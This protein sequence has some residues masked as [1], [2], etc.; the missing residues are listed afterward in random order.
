MN[1][2]DELNCLN[3][4]KRVFITGYKGGMAHL[5][6]SFSSIE[7]IYTLYMKG[8]MKQDSKRADQQDKDRFVLSKGHAGLALYSVLEM[9]GYVS[10]HE[11]ESYLMSDGKIGGE[12]NL[13]D[14]QGIEASTGSL[15]HGLPI[16]LGMAMAQKYDGNGL[17]TFVLIGDGEC[18]EGTIWEAAMSAVSFELDNLIVILDCNMI[19]KTKRVDEMMRFVAWE[20]KWKAF[21]WNTLTAD[22]HNIDSLLKAFMSLPQ[23]GRP[24]IIIA[25]TIKG[26]GVSIM[27]NNPKW[28]FKL[29]N[30]QELKVF[31]EELNIDENELDSRG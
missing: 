29:P 16:A 11:M 14:A 8:I 31:M 4:R 1:H 22:G 30:K 20:E 5:A 7:I 25:N 9:A 2:I 21:G 18:Q 19:Q 23:N 28:H 26:R 24:T 15:G 27:E 13:G 3:L 17:R 6:S 10:K 12:P